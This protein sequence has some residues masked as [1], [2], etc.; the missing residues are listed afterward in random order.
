MVTKASPLKTIGVS[1]GVHESLR[2]LRFTA[3]GE[4]S[5]DKVIAVLL[6]RNGDK[7]IGPETISGERSLNRKSDTSGREMKGL[8]FRAKTEADK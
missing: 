8:S 4:I 1:K 2:M 6:L 5:M 7:R 3:Y